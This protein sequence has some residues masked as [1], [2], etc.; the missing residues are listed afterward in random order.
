[1]SKKRRT[2]L[3]SDEQIIEATRPRALPI[4][5]EEELKVREQLIELAARTLLSRR[6]GAQKPRDQTE[7]VQRRRALIVGEYWHL[8]QNQRRPP[9]DPHMIENLREILR[10]QHNLN[11]SFSTIE[12][13]LRKIGI[14]NLTKSLSRRMIIWNANEE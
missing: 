4:Y 13:D 3:L 1:M 7:R 8:P 10:R 9:S 11:V 5:T 12:R 6:N 14:R 2:V